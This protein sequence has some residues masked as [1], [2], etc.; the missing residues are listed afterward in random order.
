MPQPAQPQ[1][2]S[3][4]P[5]P[6]PILIIGAG[7]GGLL[8]AQGLLAHNNNNNANPIPFAIYDRDA[9]PAA[10]PQGYRIRVAGGAGI[11][12]LEDTLP[13]AVFA[14]FEETCA[15]VELRGG[16]GGG[17][18][19]G[20]G[21]S[22][23]AR[24]AGEREGEGQQQRGGH[25]HGHGHG[26]RGGGMDEAREKR[27]REAMGAGGRRP[28]TP[29]R[30]A[31]KGV[32]MEGGVGERV[33]WGKAFEG[34]DVE[35][36]GEEEGGGKVVVARFAD[37]STARGCL[38]VGADGA[39][40]RV[41][42]QF[43]RDGALRPVDT[44]GRL[45]YGKTVLNG[46]EGGVE[47]KMSEGLL[48]RGMRVVEDKGRADGGPVTCLYEAVRF[49]QRGEVEG[50]PEEDYVYWVLVS[51]K[52]VFGV[53]DEALGR[54]SSEEARKLALDITKEWHPQLRAL[55]EL[56]DPS[57]TAAMRVLSMRP[58]LASWEPLRE[59]VTLLG[60][61]AH[62]MSPSGGVG[63]VTAFRDAAGLTKVLVENGGRVSAESIG[64]YED[65]MRKYAKEAIEQSRQG[66]VRFF[67]HPPFEECESVD[68]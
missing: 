65:A 30:A 57:Q 16:G 41:R 7:L 11:A 19:G 35:E 64:K 44:R 68:A 63:A 22:V 12:A 37:G 39:R 59:P 10:R 58:E 3:Q 60:D 32:L 47:G 62:V 54:M 51:R 33:V 61:A 53:D 66:G 21:R 45:V 4:P 49:P 25:G 8:L 46:G 55:F 20:P 43:L 2:Q 23:D 9:A 48:E 26:H 17:G 28:Y 15:R 27:V 52:E 38:L 56:A 18:P 42:R 6:L 31:L 1:P 34:Y 36:G 50:C 24:T 5:Q 40:S 67:N 13:P 14:R 29:D